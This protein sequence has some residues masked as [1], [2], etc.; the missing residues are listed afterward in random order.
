MV[1]E[2]LINISYHLCICL[3][4]NTAP[5]GDTAEGE[6]VVG[7]VVLP[8]V[9]VC[10]ESGDEIELC[11]EELG[12]E[13]M[14][15]VC[16]TG[17]DVTVTDDSVSFDDDVALTDIV[18]LDNAVGSGVGEI[19]NSVSDGAGN[20]EDDTIVVEVSGD[21]EDGTVVVGLKTFIA[22]E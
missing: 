12:V 21:V 4:V 11:D 5:E 16:I 8:A 20:A 2:Q 3:P 14:L 22:R 6:A 15:N 9:E 1:H 13:V 17:D 10:S 7:E 19:T 18:T